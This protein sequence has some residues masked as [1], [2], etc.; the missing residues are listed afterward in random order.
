MS[1]DVGL[2]WDMKIQS[3]NRTAVKQ[4]S[5][6]LGIPFAIIV[7]FL[8][9]IGDDSRY[10]F[11]AVAFI[12]IFLVIGLTFAWLLFGMKYVRFD[13][14]DEY[15]SYR[16]L[17][18]SVERVEKLRT[19]NLTVGALTTNPSMVG[20][21]LLM[22]SE[23]NI[24]I[25]WKNVKKVVPNPKNNTIFLKGPSDNKSMTIHCGENYDVILEYVLSHTDKK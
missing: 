5:L 22:Q 17:P 21:A 11:Y 16:D 10:A 18:R 6:V 14:D 25:K 1:N 20:G 13:L 7:I 23:T 15:A 8:L 2:E 3:W 9:S 4:I 24:K 19:F 12:V